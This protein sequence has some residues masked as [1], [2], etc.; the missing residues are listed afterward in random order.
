MMLPPHTTI[1]AM[2]VSCRSLFDG[3]IVVEG[4]RWVILRSRAVLD[5]VSIQCA[6]V[7]ASCRVLRHGARA[8]RVE[9]GCM[10]FGEV[11]GYGVGVSVVLARAATTGE[12]N[13]EIHIAFEAADRAAVR[14]FFDA[15]VARGRRSCCTNR[16]SG[17][18]TTPT[19]TGR[20]CAIPTATTSK[21]SA[22]CRS[23][24][25]QPA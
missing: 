23:S 9:L 8:A 17:P 10:D 15:A 21:P 19:T 4:N 14:A 25:R 13:R 20:S 11:L 2:P 7:G 12:P 3:R 18:S 24:A 5:H 6:D 22:T 16:A 1:V